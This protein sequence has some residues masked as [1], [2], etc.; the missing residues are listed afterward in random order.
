MLPG[1][2]GRPG[3]P[4]EPGDPGGPGRP[5]FPR[6]PGGPIE[7]VCR[8]KFKQ[9][10]NSPKKEELITDKIEDKNPHR[11]HGIF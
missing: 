7:P 2:P 11:M 1:G 5:G 3:V 8:Y 10:Q 4:G 6:L 9:K